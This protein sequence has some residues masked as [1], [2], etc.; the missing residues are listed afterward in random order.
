MGFPFGD[1]DVMAI[2]LSYTVV[3]ASAVISF[4]VLQSELL[5]Y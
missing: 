4:V 2:E 5:L 3:Q 1:K